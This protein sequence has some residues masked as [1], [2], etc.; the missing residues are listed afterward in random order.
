MD[1][2]GK[3]KKALRN[4][5][6]DG[7]YIHISPTSIRWYRPDDEHRLFW[8]VSV[9]YR[10]TR[11]TIWDAKGDNLDLILRELGEKI[12]RRSTIESGFVPAT[13]ENTQIGSIARVLKNIPRPKKNK[14][15]IEI[16]KSNLED[17]PKKPKKKGKKRG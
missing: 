5:T 7:Y 6:A 8:S 13:E 1:L 9:E 10:N 15:Y 11:W 17:H 16:R 2:S 14:V 3:A 12:P 4:W